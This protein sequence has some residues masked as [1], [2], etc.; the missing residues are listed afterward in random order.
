MN[1][2]LNTLVLA[3]IV[4]SP[5][6][7]NPTRAAGVFSQPVVDGEAI[8][9][10]SPGYQADNFLLASNFSIAGVRLWGGYGFDPTPASDQFS[11]SF[12]GDTGVGQ[13]ELTSLFSVSL[14]DAARTPTSF[15][16]VVFG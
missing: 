8:Y 2:K 7:S 12:F 13:P 16:T 5:I 11:I 15:L 6:N 9:D 10:A 1:T 14:L 4:F 3:L